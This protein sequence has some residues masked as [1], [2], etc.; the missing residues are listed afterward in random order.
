MKAAEGKLTGSTLSSGNLGKCRL[1]LGVQRVS[2][3]DENDRKV[4]VNQCK[5]PMLEFTGQ[6]LVDSVR[7]TEPSCIINSDLHL[8]NAYKRPL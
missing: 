1:N 6:N 7:R 3:H 8:Q 2:G 4:L 5:R